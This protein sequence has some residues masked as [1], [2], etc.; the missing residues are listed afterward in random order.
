M[1]VKRTPELAPLSRDHHHALVAAQRLRQATQDSAAAAR[2][3]AIAYWRSDGEL[4]FRLEEEVLLPAYAD[5]GDAYAD[6]VAHVLCDHVA[7]RSR[8]AA[9]ERDQLSLDRMRDLGRRLAEHVRLE[10]RE[11]FPLIERT[12]PPPALAAVADALEH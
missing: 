1:D 5:H 11:L 7:L 9:L 2:E 8:I 12:L 4:H 3:Q 6:L 10:E